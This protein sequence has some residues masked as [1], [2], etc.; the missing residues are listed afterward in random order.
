[1]KERVFFLGAMSNVEPAYQAANCL[2]HPTLEDT[3]AMVVLEAMAHGLPVVV[4][5]AGYCG[6]ASLLTDGEDA[7]LLRNPLNVEA[8]VALLHKAL[9]DLELRITLSSAAVSF[10]NQHLWSQQASRLDMIYQSV[11]LAGPMQAT[12]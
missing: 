6:I 1:L 9:F 8:M 5:D 11:S 2:A 3:F 7:L 12:L 10:A 4:S